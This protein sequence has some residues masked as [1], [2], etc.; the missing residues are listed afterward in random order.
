[1]AIALSTAGITV[2]YAVGATRP[3]ANYTLIP[4][5]KSIPAFG[6]D[7]N[8]LQSTPLS[9]TVSHT[10]IAG[11]KD[12]GGAI[13]LT[14]ND[15]NEFKTAWEGAITAYAGRD[16]GTNMWWEYKIPGLTKSF[17]F[18]GEPIALGFGGADVDSVLETTA[19]IVPNGDYEWATASTVSP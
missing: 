8:T 19:N 14:A 7:V 2:G 15:S 6:D 12:S 10:Y 17:F 13:G 3:T 16:S 5:V 11:L 18:P 1:M 9:A 4:D